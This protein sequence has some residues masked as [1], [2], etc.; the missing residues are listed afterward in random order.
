MNPIFQTL[1]RCLFHMAA[2]FIIFLLIPSCADEPEEKPTEKKEDTSSPKLVG[3]VAS[4]PSD[5]KFV[6]IQA[7]GIWK[8][9]TGAI[10]TTQGPGERAANL[11]ATGEKL[12]QY[13]AADIQ[14]GTLEIGDG[15]YTVA[16]LPK[17]TLTTPQLVESVKIPDA[18]TETETSIES[19]DIFDLEE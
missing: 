9:E 8:V 2:L 7:Y 3:R 11:R 14:S 5:R 16:T 13:A 18:E 12:G 19:P 1:H 15:V 10:L 17:K 6:L 4:I